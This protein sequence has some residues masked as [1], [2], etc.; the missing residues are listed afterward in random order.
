[1]KN[2]FIG[3]IEKI[4]KKNSNFRRVL[5]TSKHL[6]LVIMTLKPGEDIGEEKH[7]D[8]DQFFRFESGKGKV[9]IN[10]KMHTVKDGDAVIVPA[11][12]LHNVI[13]TSTTPLKLY[14]LYSP[15]EHKDQIVRKTKVSALTKEEHYEGKT[16][17]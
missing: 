11:G 2:G 15:P 6:Q 14:T 9:E 16:T 12:A 10:K 8:V 3:Q 13:N 1:M 7:D 4:T 17:E 5:Y